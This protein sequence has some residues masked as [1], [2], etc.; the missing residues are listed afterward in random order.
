MK[1]NLTIQKWIVGIGVLLFL[2]KI[3]AWYLTNSVAILTDALE[4]T[5]NVIS[6]FIGLYS[7]YLSSLPRDENH[8]YGHGKVEFISAAIEGTLISV[9]GLIIVYETINNLKHPH[10][11]GRLDTGIL[12]IVFT[13]VVNYA[14]GW[15]ATKKGRASNS[16]ALIASGKHLQTDTYTTVGIIIGLVLVRLTGFA[17]LDSIVALVF[18]FV[19]LLSGYQI[20]RDSVKGIMDEA[21][22]QLIATFAQHLQANRKTTWIDVHNARFIKYGPQLHLDCHITVPAYHSVQ[23]AHDEIDFLD[24]LVNETFHGRVELFVHTDPCQAFQCSVCAVDACPIRST[25]FERQLP[26]TS[27]NIALNR[28]HNK[29]D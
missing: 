5:V 11:L 19:I 6:A 12:L 7:L 25:S 2:V 14:M 15:I 21:D 1:Q 16:L 9:A 29:P 26:W 22:D 17:L 8:P 4:S 13:A 3:T 20:L 27:E 24:Q 23:E 28:Q 18:A 10:P